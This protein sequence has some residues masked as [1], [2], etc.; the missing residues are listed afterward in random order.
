M[1]TTLALHSLG[2]HLLL[3]LLLQL[4]LVSNDAQISQNY[5]LGS[6]L[7]ARE[8]DS[9]WASPLGDFSFGFQQVGIG[10]FLLAIWFNRI[11]EKIVFWS[12]NQDNLC[13]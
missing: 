5:T 13:Q 6:S 12:A 8:N 7:V 11:P 3:L 4:Q 1:A 2:H 10:G 9:F